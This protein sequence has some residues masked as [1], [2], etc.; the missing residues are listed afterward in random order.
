MKLNDFLRLNISAKTISKITS[1]KYNAGKHFNENVIW[2][3]EI[4]A[5]IRRQCGA[6]AKNYGYHI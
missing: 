2:N 5:E 3:D 4:N 6:L 1:R